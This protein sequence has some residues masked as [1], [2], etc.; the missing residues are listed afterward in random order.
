[1]KNWFKQIPTMKSKPLSQDKKYQ[2]L[3]TEIC[4]GCCMKKMTKGLTPLMKQKLSKNHKRKM[5]KLK[6]NFTLI[7]VIGMIV[8]S[9]YIGT[10]LSGLIQELK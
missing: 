6:A 2:K 8:D 1:M 7:I 4:G 3:L 9:N 10:I 5:I